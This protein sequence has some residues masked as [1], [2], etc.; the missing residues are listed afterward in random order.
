MTWTLY[1]R[2]YSPTGTQV[3]APKAERNA[4]DTANADTKAGQPAYE[5]QT[6]ELT[7]ECVEIDFAKNA[8]V[9]RPR[10]PHALFKQPFMMNRREHA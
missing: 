2:G 1:I 6:F 10:K 5:Q 3:I 7:D 4:C 8:W 9:A